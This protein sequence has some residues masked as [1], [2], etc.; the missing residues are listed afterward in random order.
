MS[1]RGGAG[2]A[3]R[4]AETAR[5]VNISSVLVLT[6][7]ASHGFRDSG[8]RLASS[9]PPPPAAAAAAPSPPAFFIITEPISPELL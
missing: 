5:T 7:G 4:D 1:R 3:E 9:P 8:A 6:H 2:R